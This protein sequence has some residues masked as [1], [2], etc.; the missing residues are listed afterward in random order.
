[1]IGLRRALAY[2]DFMYIHEIWVRKVVVY[3]LLLC[4]S[5]EVIYMYIHLSIFSSILVLSAV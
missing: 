5:M 2:I 3:V 4:Q 1:M